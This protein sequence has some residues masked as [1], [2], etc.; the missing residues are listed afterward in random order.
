[1]SLPMTHSKLP[2]QKTP[3]KA[4]REELGMTQA[5]FAVALDIDTSTVSRC[6]RSLSEIALTLWQVKRLCKLTGRTLDQLPDR[7]VREADI[8]EYRL[9]TQDQE[10][11]LTP[12]LLRKRASKTQ[13]Q[14]AVELGVTESVVSK[15][16][17]SI[18]VPSPS[19]TDIPKYCQ[20][21]D[22]SFEELIEAF[23]NLSN[24]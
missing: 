20:A 14:I 10:D 5:Q 16:E 7:L 3:L 1:M 9:V 15:W 22:C 24:N 18:T 21:Y 12:V 8:E 2:P 6:E 23:A 4:I 17:R 11:Q 13:R 19:L